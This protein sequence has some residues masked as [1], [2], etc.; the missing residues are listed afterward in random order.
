M[1]HLLTTTALL[2]GI[3]FG[4]AAF[5][6]DAAEVPLT[7]ADGNTIYTWTVDGETFHGTWE[8]Y[9][10]AVDD[11]AQASI[12]GATIVTVAAADDVAPYTSTSLLDNILADAENL[13]ASLSNVS[14]NLNNINGS[15]EVNTDRDYAGIASGINALVGE[16]DGFGSFST[17]NANV[18]GVDLPASLLA[19]LDPLTLELG[20]LSTTAIGTLQSGNMTGS[21]DASGIV[22]KVTSEA[23]GS[24]TSASMLAETYGGIAQTVAMQN[25]SVNSGDING[26]VDL[27][28]ADVN[29]K[30]GT[31]ATTAIGA[32]QSGAMTATVDGTIGSVS[33]NSAA[34][35]DALVGG[36]TS[37]P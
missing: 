7:D 5:A 12:S 13:S 15:I 21:F 25:V 34:L 10:E 27:V 30:V 37:T 24:T 11:N 28:M 3:A 32:L 8:Q 19:V 33:H 2:A 22:N 29:A 26:S 36:G 35:V 1:K 6:Q 18:Y 9:E 20:N 16:Y 4:G 31:V 17:V 23:S 14:Q